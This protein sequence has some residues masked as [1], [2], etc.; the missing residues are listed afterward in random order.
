MIMDHFN[1]SRIRHVVSRVAL[2]LRTA[3]A[4]LLGSA[5]LALAIGVA[6]AQV[7]TAPGEQAE[8]FRQAGL[9]QVA[10]GH[11][12]EAITS[13]RCG[14]QIAPQ[15]ARLLDA[16]GAA[17][18]LK[19]DLETAQQYFVESL[20][21]DPAS[22][23]TRQNLGIALFSLGRYEDASKQFAVIR[24]ASGKPPEVASLFLGLIAQK[25][26]NCTEALP[27]L[28]A[29]GG[30][31]YQYPDAL[32]TYSECEYEKGNA[33][34]ATDGLAAFEQLKGNTP[35]QYRQA[36][37]LYRQLGLHQKASED[38]KGAQA[39]NDDAPPT[40]LN[41][42]RLLE[43]ANRSDEARKL[44]EDDTASQPTY[45][46]LLELAKI[47]KER[48]DFAVAMKSLKRVSQIEPGREE[49]YLEFSNICADHGNDQLAL[50]S[51]EI[52]LEHVP[53]SYELTVQKGVVQEKLGHLNDA[54]ETLRKAI[55]MQKDNSIALLSLAVVQ[56]H[57]GRTDAA[58]ET[59]A[60][61]IRQF[62]D[63][64]Y[65]YYFQGKLLMQF[66]ADKP[67]T[68]RLQE[69]AK[70]SFERAIQLNPTYADSYYQLSSLYMADS[71]R[72]SEQALQKCLKIDPNHIAAQYALARLYLRTG[73]RADGEEML[74]HLKTQQRSQELKQQRQL[75]IEVAQN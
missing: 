7:A 9:A 34:R 75:R 64:Y 67:D 20:K 54:E 73:R 8:Q 6:Q 28:E 1:H 63:N 40:V 44:L 59:L 15:D 41:Q 13:F 39:R 74:A 66:G 49:S 26:S 52:G 48:G 45:D 42:A 62:P 61:A 72:L 55:A 46:S 70:Q 57:S 32:L 35:A 58:E 36:A 27:L 60:Q 16:I 47:A 11:V 2:N 30:L 31:L 69:T 29:S 43:K 22:V 50:D 5:C 21:I 71:P 65:M 14:L 56:A 19:N 3:H 12:D 33:R 10:S 18:T 25:Q 53:D 37:V 68:T 24:E 17:Y 23:S 38:R 51:A 4:P